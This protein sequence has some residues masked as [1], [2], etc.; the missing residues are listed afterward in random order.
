MLVIIFD[1]KTVSYILT[2][3]ADRTSHI[4]HRTSH[5][6]IMHYHLALAIWRDAV[7]IHTYIQEEYMEAQLK[8]FFELRGAKK[9]LGKSGFGGWER[10]IWTRCLVV[11]VVV[12]RI[13]N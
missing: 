12:E 5:T 13:S 8:G 3:I 9:S 7:D 10:R 11:N 6:A 2:D 4:A 1:C